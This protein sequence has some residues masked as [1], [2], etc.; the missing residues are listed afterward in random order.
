M[1]FS[2]DSDGLQRSP[3]RDVGEALN[4]AE[5]RAE[6]LAE[7]ATL[8]RMARDLLSGGSGGMGTTCTDADGHVSFVPGGSDGSRGSDGPRGTD[9]FDGRPGDPGQVT[10]V[11]ESTK[12]AAGS[13]RSDS[14]PTNPAH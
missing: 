3:A 6:I 13:P 12:A 1:R 11:Y 2:P 8:Q 9:G 10:I 14:P 7:H 5:R 4:N